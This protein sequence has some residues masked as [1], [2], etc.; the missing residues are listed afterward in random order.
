MSLGTVLV[1]LAIL[2]VV[3]AYVAR[4]FKHVAVDVDATVEAWVR[5][6]RATS[7]AAEMG[8]AEAEIGPVAPSSMP[9]S[10]LEP[11]GA[12]P[13]QDDEA[14]NFCPHCGRRVEP[15]HLFCPRC[16]KSLGRGAAQ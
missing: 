5:Q 8:D 9:P 1:S 3:V 16:G 13:L 15:D 7:S 14:T 11:V 6:A 2:S 4:P 10:T 12:A